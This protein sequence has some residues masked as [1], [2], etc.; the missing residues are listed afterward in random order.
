MIGL[1]SK[2]KSNLLNFKCNSRVATYSLFMFMM[3]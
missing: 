2:K 1:E 3:P